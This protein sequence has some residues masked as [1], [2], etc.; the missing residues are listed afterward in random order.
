MSI[1]GTLGVASGLALEDLVTQ[2]VSAERTPKVKQLDSQKSSI[3]VSLSALSKIRSAMGNFQ[4]S[5]DVLKSAD[6]L[7][8]RAATVSHPDDL[9]PFDVTTS[10]SASAGS[11]NISVEALASGTRATSA[12]GS[13]TGSDAVVST[14]DGVL[15]FG[16]DGDSFDVDVTA[17]MTLSQ[18]REAI[19]DKS[20]NFGV[21]ANIINTG[22]PAVGSKLVITSSITGDP[23]TKELSIT[24]NNAEL[25]AVSTVAS[26][27]G[28]AMSVISSQQAHVKI[29]GVDAYSDSNTMENVIQ[30]VSLNLKSETNGT[31]ATLDVS[32]DTETVRGYIDDFISKYN[33]LVSAIQDQ[34]KSG[35]ASADGESFSGGGPLNGNSMIRG[36]RDQLNTDIVGAVEGADSSL[37]TLFALGISINDDGKMEIASTNAFGGQTGEERMTAA[38]EGSFDKIAELFSGDNG[39]ATRIESSLE[40]YTKSKGLFDSQEEVLKGQLESIT[41]RR[42]DLDQYISGY[43]ETLRK[44]YAALDSVVASMSQTSSYLMS[45]LSSLPGFG[46]SS[47]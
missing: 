12:D 18:L 41:Q 42:E 40:Y 4:S 24:N 37:N 11:Y 36:L 1:G 2:L 29:D 45:Q 16:A 28:T 3:D 30:N 22:D 27:G 23:A 44:R 15:T 5:L 21:S 8:Q 14:T 32:T 19:N 7:M 31:A 25:D 17:G 6:S 34:T 20:D 9:T 43:E 10:G 13:F 38:L 39:I 26:G 47:N 33:S 35:T 46:G